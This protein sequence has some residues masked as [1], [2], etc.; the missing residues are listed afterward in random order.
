[1]SLVVGVSWLSVVREAEAGRLLC[2]LLLRDGP[3]PADAGER[4]RR[5]VTTAEHPDPHLASRP[6]RKPESL[7]PAPPDTRHGCEREQDNP[8]IAA[9]HTDWVWTMKHIVSFM[10]P[11]AARVE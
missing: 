5:E 1:M 11:V 2:V 10:D 7:L 4:K 3:M 8:A 9:R 6:G